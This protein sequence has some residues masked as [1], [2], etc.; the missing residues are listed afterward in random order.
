MPE[1]IDPRSI[2]RQVDDAIYEALL[3]LCEQHGWRLRVQGHKFRVY[4][5]CGHAGGGRGA[6]VP[7]T[8]KH[9]ESAARRLL[10]N[11]EHCPDNHELIT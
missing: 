11:A 3:T 5:P 10:R 7:G 9:P 2:R 6:S 1:W 8:S 4:C